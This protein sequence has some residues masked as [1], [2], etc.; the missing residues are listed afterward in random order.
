MTHQFKTTIQYQAVA[1]QNLYL[2]VRT[3]FISQGTS[4]NQWCIAHGVNRQTA[5]RALAGLRHSARSRA[6]VDE[7]LAAAL[8]KS[9]RRNG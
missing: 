1:S 7:I 9:V 2:A 4:L 6:L 3:G 5:E 8:P